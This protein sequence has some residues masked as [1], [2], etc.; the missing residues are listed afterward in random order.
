MIVAGFG[1]RHGA[2]VD[3]LIDALARAQR[4]HPPAGI[5]ATLLSKIP[6]VEQLAEILGIPVLAYGVDAAAGMGTLTQSPASHTAKG[7]GS[8]AEAAALLGAGPGAWLLSPRHIS[9]DRMAT[10]ALARGVVQ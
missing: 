3:S 9:S 5:V 2:D 10:C 8:V 4:G 1:F 7:T 6:L